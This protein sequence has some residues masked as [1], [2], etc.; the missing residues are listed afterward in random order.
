M[1]KR[2]E[3]RIKFLGFAIVGLMAMS[4]CWPSPPNIERVERPTA[5]DTLRYLFLGHTYEW[6]APDQKVDTRVELM[7]LNRYDRIWLGGDVCS[8]SSLD[9]STLEYIDSIFDLKAPGNHFALGN[10]DIRNTNIEWIEEV[11]ERKTYYAYYENDI[12]TITLNS[13]LTPEDCQRLDEQYR[14]IRDVCDTIEE[15][16]HLILLMHHGIYSD[17]IPGLPS[18]D[19]YAHGNYK[20]WNAN[21]YSSE[22]HFD[23]AIYPLLVEAQNRGVQVICVVGDA[24]WGTLKAA[25]FQADAG[26]WFLASGITNSTY[27]NNPEPITSGFPGDSVLIFEHILDERKLI[28]DM[29][30]LDSLYLSHQ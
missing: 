19:S 21:C 13:T 23:N 16:S 12:T 25:E 24:G 5:S 30:D 15:S 14:L 2:P 9:Y 6:H 10:H 8:E 27:L 3:T 11:T 26:V 7:D 22:N 4:F 29:H 28:W 20:Y 18:P 1:I 17:N